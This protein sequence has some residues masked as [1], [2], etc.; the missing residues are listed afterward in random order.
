MN[1][2]KDK[3]LPVGSGKLSVRYLVGLHTKKVVF[4]SHL[5]CSYLYVG[6]MSEV[7]SKEGCRILHIRRS[8]TET[9]AQDHS[10]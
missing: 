7:T 9:Y 6:A 5:Y 3:L 4:F 8:T 1:V 2:C 10:C